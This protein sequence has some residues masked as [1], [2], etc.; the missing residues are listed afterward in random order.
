MK[1]VLALSAVLGAFSLFASSAV[2]QPIEIANAAEAYEQ[3]KF[4]PGTTFKYQIKWNTLEKGTMSLTFKGM[5]GANYDFGNYLLSPELRLER[6][7]AKRKRAYAPVQFPLIPGTK[8]HYKDAF[9]AAAAQ[10]G[11]VVHDMTVETGNLE[12]VELAGNKYEVLRIKHS[13]TSTSS[14]G[15]ED[16]KRVYLYSP[17]LGIWV[18][19]LF[20]IEANGTSRNRV[21]RTLVS[22][23]IPTQ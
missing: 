7:N 6:K 8:R 12:T 19:D 16:V 2:L 22:A 1:N 20:N 21:E 10:C 14:C 17:K 23:S 4:K 3:P 9:G 15:N 13:G 5:D 11:E 18:Y